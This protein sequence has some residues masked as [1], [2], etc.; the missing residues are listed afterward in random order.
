M[1]LAISTYSLLRWR[2]EERT[3]VEQTIDW[4]ASTGVRAIEFAKLDD[5]AVANP[6]RRARALRKRCE[7]N[8]LKVAGYCIYAELLQ[9]PAALK[10]TVARLKS[11]VDVAAELGAPTMRHDV[12]WGPDK[13]ADNGWTTHQKPTLAEVLAQVAPPI[14]EVA[15]YGA[16]Q[17][18]KMSL[19]NHGRYMQPSRV[20]E[21]LLRKVNHPKFG[22][23]LDMG[24]FLVVDEDP[25]EAV[26]RLV[27]YAIMV[28]VKD[29][30]VR[31]IQT[32]PPNGWSAAQRR[33]AIRGA[34]VGHGS[35]D[36]PA[37]LRLLKKAGYNGYLS[38]EFEGLEEP[39]KAVQMGLDYL[40]REM[41]SAGI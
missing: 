32:M 17:G 7:K 35:I 28:H 23:T 37:Q 38:L 15:D 21:K 24:N 22:L 12:T 27:K 25:V 39:R 41:K 8:G 9:P 1:K 20:V 33:I 2:R 13:V 4:I 30:H 29:F 5:D 16:Q 11:E 14:R 34:I 26:R 6:L 36:V 18:I 31:P 10:K 40:R 19:E 3:S